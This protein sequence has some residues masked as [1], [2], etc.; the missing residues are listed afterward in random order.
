M[1]LFFKELKKAEEDGMVICENKSRKKGSKV[2]S[3]F[4]KYSF[5]ALIDMSRHTFIEKHTIEEAGINKI[6]NGFLFKMSVSLPMKL[7]SMDN[8]T[9]TILKTDQDI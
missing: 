9:Q 6:A 7:N 5:I 8:Y 2:N 1:C 3:R 4:S